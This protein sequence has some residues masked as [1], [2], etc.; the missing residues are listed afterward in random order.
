MAVYRTSL[1]GARTSANYHQKFFD[2]LVGCLAS[3]CRDGS[4]TMVSLA[5]PVDPV[6][7]AEDLPRWAKTQNLLHE[8]DELLLRDGAPLLAVFLRY[9]CSSGPKNLPGEP[10]DPGYVDAPA[11]AGAGTIHEVQHS[12]GERLRAAAPAPKPE[13]PPKPS[14]NEGKWVMVLRTSDADSPVIFQGSPLDIDAIDRA[15]TVMTDM[16]VALLAPQP[17]PTA[18]A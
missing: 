17:T 3:I 7:K 16:L 4:I 5:P 15:F 9:Q 12:L 13:A 11:Y 10:E 6:E 1:G 18:K 14:F 8:R 2:T